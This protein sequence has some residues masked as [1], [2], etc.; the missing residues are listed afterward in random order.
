M[1][2]CE[3]FVVMSDTMPVSLQNW[4]TGRVSILAQIV[5]PSVDV[6]IIYDTL[7]TALSRPR[8]RLSGP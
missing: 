8:K 3:H 7:M 6:A 4:N 2:R 1:Y 5:P